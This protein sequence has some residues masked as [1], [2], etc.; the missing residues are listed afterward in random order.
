MKSRALVS[1]LAL[2]LVLS[3]A[4]LAD[5]RP[6]EGRITKIDHDARVITIQDEVGDQWDFSWTE[7]TRVEGDA[8]LLELKPGDYV[9]F[10]YQEREGR[11]FLTE[12]R[13]TSKAKWLKLVGD[14]RQ[15]V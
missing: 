14:A 2:A 9:H 6:D 15:L 5:D 13:R 3:A 12:I 4:A 7:S 11:K 10:D 8:P 1:A